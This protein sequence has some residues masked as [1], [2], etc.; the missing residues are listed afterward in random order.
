VRDGDTPTFTVGLAAVLLAH[1]AGTT[2]S[3]AYAATVLG[4]TVSFLEFDPGFAAR[5]AYD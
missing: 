5:I 4:Q 2:V 3:I 1:V